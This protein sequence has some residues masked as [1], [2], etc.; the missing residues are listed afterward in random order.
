M[1]PSTEK[2]AKQIRNKSPVCKRS[3]HTMPTSITTREFCDSFLITLVSRAPRTDGLME[4][5]M[6]TVSQIADPASRRFDVSISVN[7]V[8]LDFNEYVDRINECLDDLVIR[9]ASKIF[10]DRS[11]QLQAALHDLVEHVKNLGLSLESEARAKWG[12]LDQ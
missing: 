11:R 10:D 7:G 1:R 3:F 2:A 12:I 9:T 4:K 5:I 6:E 8:E